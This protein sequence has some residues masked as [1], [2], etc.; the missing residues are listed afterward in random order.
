MTV[1]E[2]IEELSTLQEDLVLYMWD[3]GGS[4][5][6]LIGVDFTVME[7]IVTEEDD[8]MEEEG[9]DIVILEY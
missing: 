6:P 2:L 3:A 1:K 4:D 7:R 8:I 5:R 9:T